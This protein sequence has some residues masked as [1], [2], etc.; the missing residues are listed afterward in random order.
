LLSNR[1]ANSFGKSS[2]Q[3]A[4]R[5]EEGRAQGWENPDAMEINLNTEERLYS[6]P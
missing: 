4:D 6:S 3:R 2:S 5:E 1:L